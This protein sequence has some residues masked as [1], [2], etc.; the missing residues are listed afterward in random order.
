MFYIFLYGGAAVAAILT[1]FLFNK[2]YIKKK[3]DSDGKLIKNK[4]TNNETSNKGNN[5]KRGNKGAKKSVTLHSCN[6]LPM[7]HELFGIKQITGNLIEENNGRLSTIIGFST[8]DFFALSDDEQTAYEDALIRF[9]VSAPENYKVIETVASIST[10]HVA[11]NV[12]RNLDEKG[13]NWQDYMSVETR[14]YALQYMHVLR[15]M[16]FSKEENQI[17]KY[18]CISSHKEDY[19]TTLSELKLLATDF[20]NGL[21]STEQEVKLL[22]TSEIIEILNR[23]FN[24]GSRISVDEVVE[25]GLFETYSSASSF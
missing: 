22:S 12:K 1:I 25:Q 15:N 7:M 3:Y 23:S 17:I 11:N 9:C 2:F 13:E 5:Q 10:R 4:T 16:S 20:I 14:E 8:M 21:Q 24:H 6:S 19:D 18:L